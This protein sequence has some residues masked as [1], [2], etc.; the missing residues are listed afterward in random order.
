MLNPY[1]NGVVSSSLIVEASV[2]GAS[3]DK[4]IEAAEALL[5]MD[6]P[7]SLRGDRSPGRGFRQHTPTSHDL[8]PE[9][10][11]AADS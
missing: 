11:Q 3:V 8:S 1:H 2:H 5:H 6:S 10:T 4:T 7:S 9:L